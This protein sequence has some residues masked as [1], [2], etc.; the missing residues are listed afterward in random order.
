MKSNRR[1]L[2]I[3]LAVVAV[4]FLAYFI[5]VPGPF[6]Q[7]PG[8]GGPP[9]MAGGPP[10]MAGGPPGMMGRPG[11]GMGA[12]G[13]QWTENEMPKDLLMTYAKFLGQTGL[14]PVPI[15]KAFL[16][17]EEGTPQ[18][19]TRTGWQQLYN[20]YEVAVED[21]GS[22]GGRLS[23]EINTQLAVQDNEVEAI[24]ELYRAA[25]DDFWFEISYPTYMPSQV[26][27]DA[28][29]IS[30]DVIMH[31]KESAQRRYGQLIYDR[32]KSFDNP[33]QHRTSF[34]FITYQGGYW[35]PYTFQLS[36]EAVSRW[37]SL[38][39]QNQVRLQ[40]LDSVGDV[41]SSQ[42]Q[43]AGHSSDTPTQMVYPP[44]IRNTPEHGY[45][46]AA[47]RTNFSGGTF[48][49]DYAEGWR[50]TFQFTL[51][52][53]QLARLDKAEAQLIGD[54]GKV[55]SHT[56]VRGTRR[57]PYAG[58][59]P[60]AAG[61]AQAGAAAGGG[62]PSG[63]GAPAAPGMGGPPGRVGPGAQLPPAPPAMPGML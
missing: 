55:H 10:G 54:D 45:L 8:P 24:E 22:P 42:V 18:K 48:R 27:Q 25:L 34:S 47:Q 50:Y 60:A 30:I 57:G 41:L 3:I 20:L 6:A 58:E 13:L 59:L 56:L 39:S 38:W 46:S 53:R 15:P 40:L 21:I 51:G 4:A 17:D 1:S 14:M 29:T 23:R 5:L 19:Y 52:R 32:L 61:A 36:P 7:P 33:G 11:M 9:G 35:H 37:A 2:A 43:S 44:E 31:V 28:V 16:R 62:V 12:A 63:P 49:A 26:S